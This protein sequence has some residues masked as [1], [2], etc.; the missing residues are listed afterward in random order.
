MAKDFSQKPA[1]TYL[2]HGEEAAAT[3]LRDTIAKELGWNVK[4]AEWLEKVSVG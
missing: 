2:V 1:A 4:V 3:Q